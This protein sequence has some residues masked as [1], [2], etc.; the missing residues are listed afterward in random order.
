M[1]YLPAEK[2]EDECLDRVCT[3]GKKAFVTLINPT[4]NNGYELGCVFAPGAGQVRW[5]QS[6]YLHVEAVELIL[7]NKFGDMSSYNE[8]MEYSTGLYT[9]NITKFVRKLEE[10]QVG[11]L[12]FTW[13][14]F[15]SVMVHPTASQLVF[16]VIAEVDESPEW[17][18]NNADVLLSPRYNF[19]DENLP[20]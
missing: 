2:M 19:G 16:E 7:S 1:T 20:G 18:V 10:D 6:G 13:D 15:V 5:S 8:F 3:C 14:R 12:S 9:N 4:N 17:L 11:Y